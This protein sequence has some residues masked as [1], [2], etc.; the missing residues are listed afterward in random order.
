M[1]LSVPRLRQMIKG[2]LHIEVVHRK[3]TP[4]GGLGL[5][6]DRSTCAPAAACTTM[7][8]DQQERAKASEASVR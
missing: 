2:K 6:C 4:Y 8:G 7:G 3:L 1:R 5:L